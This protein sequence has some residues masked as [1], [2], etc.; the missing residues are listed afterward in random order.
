MTEQIPTL[1]MIH[2][3]LGALDCLRY[4]EHL[5]ETTD[6]RTV[7]MLG[8]GDYKQISIAE[9]TLATQATHVARWIEQ[10]GWNNT[11]VLGHSVG[12]AVAM[13]L[14]DQRPDLITAIINVE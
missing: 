5:I 3:L 14:A 7:H 13:T 2:G 9:I 10:Q 8:Y 12:G 11:Y 4:L 6:A 1:V